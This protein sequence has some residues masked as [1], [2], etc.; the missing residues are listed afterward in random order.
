MRR[1]KKREAFDG[2]IRMLQQER[3][4]VSE[5]DLTVCV[6]VCFL[7]QERDEQRNCEAAHRHIHIH[8]HNEWIAAVFS[9]ARQSEPLFEDDVKN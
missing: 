2:T 6:S 7:F 8:T 1:S 4:S 5:S 9:T 3:L